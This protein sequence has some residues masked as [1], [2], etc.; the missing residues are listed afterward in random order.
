MSK[1]IRRVK[2]VA[3]TLKESY[4]FENDSVH[5]EK[6]CRTRWTDHKMK[7]M[8]KLNNKFGVFAIHLENVISGTSKKCGHSTLQG[9]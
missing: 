2:A 4:V 5:P 9:Q 7:A 1:K 3:L 8:K 6:A